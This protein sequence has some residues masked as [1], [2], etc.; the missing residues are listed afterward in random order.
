MEED[1]TNLKKIAEKYEVFLIDDDEEEELAMK[2]EEL[3]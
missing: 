3:D 2:N 1:L